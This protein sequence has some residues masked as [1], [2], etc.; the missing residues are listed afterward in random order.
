LAREAAAYRAHARKYRHWAD[1]WSN[2]AE[3]ENA[4]R[5]EIAAF[6]DERKDQDPDY[7]PWSKPDD[8]QRWRS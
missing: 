1:R 8:A 5:A 2:D 3:A 6:L 4:I 7:E